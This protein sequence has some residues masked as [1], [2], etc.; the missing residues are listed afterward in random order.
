VKDI[1]VI[2]FGGSLAKNKAAGKKFLDELSSLSKKK[3]VVLVHGG[4]SEINEWL[5][6]LGIKSRF[7]DGLRYTDKTT[8][9][10]VEMV[11]SGKLNKFIVGELYV[12]GVLA[13]GISGRDCG[14]APSKRIKRLGFVGEPGK[15]NASVVKTLISAGFLPVVSSLGIGPSGKALN[16]NADSFAMAL[17]VS[18]KARRLILLTDVC[19]VLDGNKRTL[20]SIR[21]SAVNKLISSGVVTGGMIPKLKACANSVKKGIKEVWIADGRKGLKKLEGTVIK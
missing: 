4:G 6:R 21:L 17:A 19:G 10:V 5:G 9:E 12:R 14:L 18:L 1:T 7:I 20:P 8:L 16:L 15:L 3:A 11:L 2:K 13:C